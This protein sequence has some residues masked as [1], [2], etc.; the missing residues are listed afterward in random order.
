MGVAQSLCTLSLFFFGQTCCMFKKNKFNLIMFIHWFTSA[1]AARYRKGKLK[2]CVWGVPLKPALKQPTWMDAVKGPRW[3][4]QWQI[5]KDLKRPKDQRGSRDQAPA[6]WNCFK[7][8]DISRTET[9]RITAGAL[10]AKS[11]ENEW[12]SQ[13]I[14]VKDQNQSWLARTNQ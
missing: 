8:A 3:I 7:M 4:R 14:P 11:T 2:R 13:H 10:T 12:M 9:C 5:K 1:G 6:A